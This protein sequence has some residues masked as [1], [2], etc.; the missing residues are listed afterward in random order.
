MLIVPTPVI[1]VWL[2][3]P[4]VPSNVSTT[5]V[6]S[7]NPLVVFT[8]VVGASWLFPVVANSFHLSVLPPFRYQIV[9]H[10]IGTS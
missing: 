2:A 3:V 10:L 6:P 9:L 4:I 5:R 7:V 8:V 1:L